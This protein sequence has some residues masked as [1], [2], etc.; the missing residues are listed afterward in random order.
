CGI[1]LTDAWRRLCVETEGIAS[2]LHAVEGLSERDV[3]TAY[4]IG[5]D[6]LDA[7]LDE[8][9]MPAG[10]FPLVAGYDAVPDPAP[11]L[12]DPAEVL[13]PLRGLERRTLSTD[14]LAEL[15]RHLRAAY[16]AGRGGRVDEED[17]PAGTGGD[18]SD[19]E[20]ES[21]VAVSGARIP[22]PAETF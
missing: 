12:P 7:V 3:V 5:G 4:G 2:V 9:G 6:D 8:T 18:A 1:S 10:W 22:I 21:E 15:K 17:D 13:G 16:E 20:D 19:D 14:A 11:G